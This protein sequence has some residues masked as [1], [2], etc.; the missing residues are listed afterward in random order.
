VPAKMVAHARPTAA[1]AA[2]ALVLDRANH[3]FAVVTENGS[4]E[5]VA[6]VMAKVSV[7]MRKR[8]RR[9]VMAA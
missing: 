9:H 1:A 8:K 2:R 6:R 5:M 3:G 4:T 7:P